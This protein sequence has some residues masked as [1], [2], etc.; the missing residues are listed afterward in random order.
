MSTW[1]SRFCP[2]AESVSVSPQP[3]VALVAPQPDTG[4]HRW[5]WQRYLRGWGGIEAAENEMPAADLHASTGSLHIIKPRGRSQWLHLCPSPHRLHQGPTRWFISA[6]SPTGFSHPERDGGADEIYACIW[7][8]IHFGKS[9]CFLWQ[10]EPFA[11]VSVVSSTRFPATHTST[12]PG[13]RISDGCS[14]AQC[15]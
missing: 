2:P 14:C 5:L 4:S 15:L 10:K 11:P 13:V 12:T 1:R 8:E 3:A 7:D 6:V 9:T